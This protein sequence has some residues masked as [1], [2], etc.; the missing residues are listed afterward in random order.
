MKS[1]PC[2]MPGTGLKVW[3]W[4][5]GWCKVIFVSNPTPVEVGLSRV[6]GL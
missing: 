5:G 3:Q 2:T 1:Q 6:V 4:V